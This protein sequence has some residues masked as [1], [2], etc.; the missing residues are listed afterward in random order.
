MENEKQVKKP[1]IFLV[2]KILASILIV[3]GIVLIIVGAVMGNPEMSSDGWFDAQ[4]S[5]Y[6][7]IFG[8]VAAIMIGAGLLFAAFAPSIHKMNIKT[9]KY[10]I[11]QNKE[12]LQDISTQNA[13]IVSP[14]VTKVTKAV[15]EGLE[16]KK[17]CKECGA[18]I[19]ADAKFCP[20][21]G[22]KQ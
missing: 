21:C 12:D 11:D 8:G 14:G 19:D 18:K 15:K 17:F 10:I 22:K 6:G 7:C 1:K 5:R 9:K 3:A 20:T 4:T 13:E 16:E 2:L